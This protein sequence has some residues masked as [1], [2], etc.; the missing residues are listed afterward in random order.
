MTSRHLVVFLPVSA[1]PKIACGDALADALA[2]HGRVTVSSS[3]SFL[4]EPPGRSLGPADLR[5]AAAAFQAA[6]QSLDDSADG[7]NAH[8]I[9]QL[10]A[11]FIM[12]SALRGER[13]P[14]ALCAGALDHL[15]ALRPRPQ[16]AAGGPGNA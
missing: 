3:L 5:A 14:I 7:V 9:R 10:L 2:L 11:R 12:E 4:R 15:K 1:Y 13:D 16:L 8:V 6:L